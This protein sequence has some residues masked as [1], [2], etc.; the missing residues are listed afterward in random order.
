M[1]CYGIGVGRAMAAVIEQCHDD[2]GPVWPMAIAPFQVHLIG[3]NI[4]QP[5]VRQACDN[6]YQSLL[7][8]GID[9]LYD[10]RGEK[11]GFAF[12]DAD[13]IGVPLR[14]V[15][16]PKTLAQTGQLNKTGASARTHCHYGRR[17][18]FVQQ[19][20]GLMAL[21]RPDTYG[22]V[23]LS[24]AAPG[25]VPGHSAVHHRNRPLHPTRPGRRRPPPVTTMPIFKSTIISAKNSNLASETSRPA[26]ASGGRQRRVLAATSSAANT[27]SSKNRD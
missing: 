22:L 24:D 4:N 16:S 5:E 6:L 11:A 7:D 17:R 1:G 27:S 12:A 13:L 21:C 9:A 8:A 2:Y 10:D 25:L 14:L 18:R 23:A 3:L 20:I 19:Q 26:S 15:V